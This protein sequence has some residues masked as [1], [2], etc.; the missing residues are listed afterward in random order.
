MGWFLALGHTANAR[1]KVVRPTPQLRIE[2]HVLNSDTMVLDG[3]YFQYF[4]G[5]LVCKGQ[6]EKG[7]KQGKWEKFYRSGKISL[8]AEFDRGKKTGEWQYFY[9]NG[10]KAA[11]YSFSNGLRTG[12]WRGYF[13]NGE[14]GCVLNYRGDTLYGEQVYYYE[15][16]NI[17]K[18]ISIEDKA[19]KLIKNVATY[20]PSGKA[21]E[22]YT[23]I[24]GKRHGAYKKYH[25]GSII[26]EHFTYKEGRMI[27][28]VEMKNEQGTN[29][30][31]GSFEKGNGTL[32]RYHATGELYSEEKYR[33]GLAYGKARYFLNDILR[34]EGFYVEGKKIGTWKYYSPFKKLLVERNFFGK[35]NV[36]YEINYGVSGEEREEGELVRGMRE[37]N[38]KTYNYYGEVM[39]EVGYKKGYKHG[40]FKRMDGNILVE[41][42]GYFFGEKVGKWQSFNRSNKVTF[43]EVYTKSVSFDTTTLAPQKVGEYLQSESR[44]EYKPDSRNP[45]FV[46]ELIGEDEYLTENMEV[47]EEAI[48]FNVRG[49][50]LAQ[51]Q[52]DEFGAIQKVHIQRGIG[53]GCDEEV[54]RLINLLPF[55]EPALT[56]GLPTKKILVKEFQFGEVE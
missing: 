39:Q 46:G 8:K 5:E 10:Q 38:W 36:V 2:Y 35:G 51:L 15:T 37:G 26:W 52:L 22:T 9:K 20:Y 7:T 55:Y 32:K 4:E 47:P 50:V 27:E 3:P 12:T 41:K 56:N 48:K 44:Y 24:N 11:E 23:T 13:L 14:K 54:K 28:V 21:F 45:R 18:Y 42:G 30:V 29:M 6:Y 33:D 17:A 34:C 16:G 43:E 19:G 49:T 53:F 25:A 1:K 31:Y 40:T